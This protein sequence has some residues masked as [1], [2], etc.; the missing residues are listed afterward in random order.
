MIFKWQDN[1]YF[2]GAL[3]LITKPLSNSCII[4]YSFESVF[5]VYFPIYL[6]P[7]LYDLQHAIYDRRN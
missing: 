6:T 7:S 1:Q 4:I 2:G 3:T 5:I